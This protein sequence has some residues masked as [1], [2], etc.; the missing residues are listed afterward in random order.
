VSRLND[1]Y[2]AA[3]KER[4]CAKDS[5]ELEKIRKTQRKVGRWNGPWFQNETDTPEVDEVG[6]TRVTLKFKRQ[7]ESA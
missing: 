1:E 6:P 5:R 2:W 7:R 3:F 4:M